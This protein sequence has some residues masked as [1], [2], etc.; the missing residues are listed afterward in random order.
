MLRFYLSL[1]RARL[2]R[3]FAHNPLWKLVYLMTYLALGIQVLTGALMTDN[4]F[5][6]G[7]YLPSI[8]AFWAGLLLWFTILHL[9][10]VVLHD[11]KGSTSDVSGIINGYRTLP[12]ERVDLPQE[13]QNSVQ[14]VSI[15]KIMK[16]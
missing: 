6:L 8:H 16:K 7:F 10:S 2:P 14:Y 1:G 5:M 4:S 11:L 9:L 3:W 12:V 13:N 15:D